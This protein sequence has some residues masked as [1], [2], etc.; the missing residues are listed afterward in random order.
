MR[1]SF[2]QIVD[3]LVELL[4]IV[5]VQMMAG[6]LDDLVMDLVI[7][8][9]LFYALLLLAVQ[10]AIAC[11]EKAQLDLRVDL[12]G[13]QYDRPL[14]RQIGAQQFLEHRLAGR[15]VSVGMICI[16]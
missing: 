4:G 1:L 13:S 9:C 6:V 2:L 7:R 11:I 5:R 3:A 8:K 12:V 10:P 15:P 16:V 14:R